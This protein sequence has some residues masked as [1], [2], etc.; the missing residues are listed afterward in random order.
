MGPANVVFCLVD[1]FGSL[2]SHY[3]LFSGAPFFSTG[4]PATNDTP[5]LVD[6]LVHWKVVLAFVLGPAG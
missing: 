5:F 2:P 1:L 3:C 6:A 4:V